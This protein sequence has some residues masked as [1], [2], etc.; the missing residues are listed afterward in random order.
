MRKIILLKFLAEYKIQDN[1][2]YSYINE[3]IFNNYNTPYCIIVNPAGLFIYYEFNN[4]PRELSLGLM[5][6]LKNDGTTYQ[7]IKSV[8]YN[9]IH[10]NFSSIYIR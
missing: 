3:A 8:L 2:D 4:N 1:G 9:A 10:N 7:N 6:I 5:R